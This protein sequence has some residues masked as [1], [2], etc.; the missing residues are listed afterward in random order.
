MERIEPR[1]GDETPFPRRDHASRTPGRGRGPI[2]ILVVLIATFAAGIAYYFWPREA[3]PSPPERGAV[4]A[5]PPPPLAQAPR[6]PVAA[7]PAETALPALKES[8]GPVAAALSALVGLDA[9]GRVLRTGNLVHNIV[10]TID[11]LPRETVSQL[12]SPLQPVQGLPV[13]TG[14][15]ATLAL[16]PA[17]ASRYV[18]HMRVLDAVS[19]EKLVAFYRRHYPLFQEAYAGLGYP[20]RYFNDRLIEVIDH[21]LAT[22]EPKGPLLLKQPK[23]LFEF[24]DPELEEISAGRKMMLRIGKENRAKVE[25][26]LRE[27]RAALTAVS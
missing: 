18:L 15:D 13:T 27:V 9:L 24:A 22:P 1:F 20:D 4:P 7:E 26:K 19:T 6:H 25:A 8:D 2:V 21:L 12:V 11:N 10:A 5:T 23:V 16:A 17:N 14:K 3:P